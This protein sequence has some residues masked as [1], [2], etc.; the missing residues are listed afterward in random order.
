AECNGAPAT[1]APLRLQSAA[2]RPETPLDRA[3]FGGGAE[4]SCIAASKTL[5]F[6]PV[7]KYNRMGCVEGKRRKETP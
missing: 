6:R 2:G 3:C 7:P 4:L 1:G 5:A